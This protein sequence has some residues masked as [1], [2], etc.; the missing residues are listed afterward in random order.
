MSSRL[1]AHTLAFLLATSGFAHAHGVF[2]EITKR[3]AV[4]IS[5]EYD[6]GEPM[7]YAAVK[8]FSPSGGKIEHQNGR[9]DKNGRFA[10][11]P[12]S[13]GPWRIIIDAEMGHLIDATFAVDDAFQIV[14]KE[15]TERSGSKWCGLA[16]GIGIIF[17]L[18]GIA[19]RF[20]ARRRP[21]AA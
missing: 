21:P 16:A 15:E 11:V 13:P 5:A 20:L 7:S 9:T 3:D 19:S 6:D 18:W 14:A 4:L 8:I 1:L 2:H 17:G 10:F 12:D